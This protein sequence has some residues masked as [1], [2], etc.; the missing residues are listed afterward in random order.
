MRA[1]DTLA[2]PG[3]GC[4][5]L[6]AFPG[7]PGHL[8]A[9]A[10]GGAALLLGLTA[11][12]EMAALGLPPAALAARCA[13]LGMAWHHIP[14]PDMGVAE[15]AA[16]RAWP[17][18]GPRLHRLLDEERA[19]AI[20]CRMGLGRTGTLAAIVLVER[21]LTPAEAIAAVRRARRGS[22]ETAAQERW[23]ARWKDDG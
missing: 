5:L 16:R 21:G 1:F 18:L 23:I 15:A 7:R 14:I 4:L 11:H 3:G 6:S 22:I 8:E 19:V 17:A 10:D 13:A 12:Q 2:V 9:L 20:H